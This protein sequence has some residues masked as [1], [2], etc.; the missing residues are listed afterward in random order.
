MLK[1]TSTKDSYSIPNIQLRGRTLEC[2]H[3]RKKIRREGPQ[4]GHVERRGGRARSTWGLLRQEARDIWA[5]GDKTCV[6]RELQT[7]STQQTQPPTNYIRGKSFPHLWAI[8]HSWDNNRGCK[9]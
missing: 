4:G 6:D 7:H 9:S 1:V 3:T 8:T 2:K 5:Q